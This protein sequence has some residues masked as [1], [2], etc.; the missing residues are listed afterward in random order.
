MPVGASRG[1]AQTNAPPATHAKKTYN[2]C[3]KKTV[4]LPRLA[5]LT[6]LLWAV[7]VIRILDVLVEHSRQVEMPPLAATG[8]VRP[9]LG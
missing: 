9:H 1:L 3:R 8:R 7:Q 6:S 4:D 2:I 5:V